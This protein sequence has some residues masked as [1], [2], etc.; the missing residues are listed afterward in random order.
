MKLEWNIWMKKESFI[1][2]QISSLHNTWID[3]TPAQLTVFQLFIWMFGKYRENTSFLNL[4]LMQ[5]YSKSIFVN[6]PIILLCY[7]IKYGYSFGA[8]IVYCY[9]ACPHTSSDS[10]IGNFLVNSFSTAINLFQERLT[11][12]YTKALT[13]RSVVSIVHALDVRW[14]NSILW[15]DADIVL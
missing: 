13:P 9:G 1:C 14:E 3:R 4:I 2:C 15:P 11:I 10:W 6:I 5:C 8:W 12:E 7:L